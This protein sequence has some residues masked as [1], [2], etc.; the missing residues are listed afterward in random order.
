MITGKH[1]TLERICVDGC[2]SQLFPVSRIVYR[3][4][5]PENIGFD[6]KGDPI[7]IDLGLCKSL[8]QNLKNKK[9][10]GYLL[11][12]RTGSVPYMAP[13][14]VLSQ[15]YSCS[16]D[17]F[18]F[19]VLAWEIL[20][21]RAA[22]KACSRREYLHRVVKGRERMPISRRLPP[23]TRLMIKEGWNHDPVQRPS[24]KRVSVLL[25]GDLNE[26]K[27]DS[28]SRSAALS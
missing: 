9:G 24:M 14:V 25:Q 28:N 6:Y 5:K 7:I 26:L 22:F 13:E 10:I 16:C 2:I 12:P 3:D 20:S 15:P 27:S 19:A 4:I 8:S 18:S 23:L 17:V 1:E 11:T 21:L